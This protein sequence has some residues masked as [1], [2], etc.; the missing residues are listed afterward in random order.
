MIEYDYTLTRVSSSNC[1]CAT[2]IATFSTIWVG[3]DNVDRRI[4][5]SHSVQPGSSIISNISILYKNQSNNQANPEELPGTRDNRN[6]QCNIYSEKKKKRQDKK[7]FC[8]W[9]TIFTKQA[10]LGL[11]FSGQCA[12]LI[13]ALTF[14]DLVMK[15]YQGQG[16]WF[17]GVQ[18]MKRKNIIV[19]KHVLINWHSCRNPAYWR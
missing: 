17:V 8:I 10:M 2:L 3:Q 16:T 19:A 6:T 18:K 13:P 14:F 11:V 12:I 15:W 4:G 1:Q 5:A 7:P 9:A